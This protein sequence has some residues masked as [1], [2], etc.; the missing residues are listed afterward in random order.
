SCCKIF[1]AVTWERN[2][3]PVV[4]SAIIVFF[5]ALWTTCAKMLVQKMKQLIVALLVCTHPFMTDAV[6]NL[7]L[8]GRKIPSNGSGSVLI[9]DI[10][11]NNSDSLQCLS[12]IPGSP[13]S[14]WY[15]QYGNAQQRRVQSD[16]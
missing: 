1:S 4:F 2:E 10:G 16:D 15:Y 3:E 9:T 11:P 12:S 14:N 7:Q 6:L 8:R 13:S 5:V